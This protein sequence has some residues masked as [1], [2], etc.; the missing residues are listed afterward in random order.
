MRMTEQLQRPRPLLFGKPGRKLFGMLHLPAASAS[1]RAS[2]LLC[3]PFGQEA[4]QSH[5]TFKV[6]AD[7]L[8][9]AGHAVLRFDYFGTGDSEGEDTEVALASWCEDIGVANAQLCAMSSDRPVLWLGLGLGAA[10]AWLTATQ[11]AQPPERLFLWD[12][13]FDGRNYVTALRRRHDEAARDALSLPSRRVPPATDIIEAIG[14]AIVPA[15]AAELDTLEV[16][17]MPTL[18]SS[19]QVV[20]IA[21]TDSPNGAALL[22]RSRSAGMVLRHVVVASEMDWMAENIDSGKLVPGPAL[23]NL[24][25]LAGEVS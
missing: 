3:S 1:R 11:T 14:F 20:L 4:I 5:R 18:P 24:V 21:P 13:I 7:R 22:A 2:I 19:I 25:A 17:T 6:L 10:A 12:P 16:G 8:V 9:R 23:Q 15:F